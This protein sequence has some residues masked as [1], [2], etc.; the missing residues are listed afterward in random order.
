MKIR[1]LLATAMLSLPLAALAE[2]D[3]PWLTIPG[4]FLLSVNHTVQSGDNAWI[5]KIGRAS[6]RERVCLAV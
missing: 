2:S 1:T 5:G 4:Q 6:C 3:S